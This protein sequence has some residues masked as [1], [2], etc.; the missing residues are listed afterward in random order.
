[1]INVRSITTFFSPNGDGERDVSKI[2]FSIKVADDATVDVVNLDGDR[3]RRLADGVR[4]GALPAAAAGRGTARATTA[5]VVPDG[6][7]RLRVALRDEG[8]S[9]I[10]QKTM[11]VDTKAPQLDR[12]HRRA[13][14]DAT[15]PRG[16]RTSSP[17]A[18]ARSTSTSVASRA[19]R[20]S[21]TSSAPTR[22]AS[23][24]GS[25]RS[26][27]RGR[28]KRA[29]AGTA[30]STASR[31]SPAPTSIQAE[32][33]DTAGN[34]GLSPAE[35]EPGAVQG[36]PRPDRARHHGAAAGAPGDRGRAHGVLRRRA[37]RGVPLAGAPGGR[38][39]HR[40]A[41]HG[42]GREPRV[43]R[44]GRPVGR[45]PARA[46][47]RPLVDDGAVPRPGP[48]ARAGAR[49]RADAHAGSAATRSTTRRST[50]SR[51]RSPRAT[52]CAG[53]ACTWARTA[54]RPASPRTSRRC[55]CSWT[56]GRSGT[57]SR[58]TSTSTSPATRARPTAKACSWP[59]R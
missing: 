25:R 29:D 54:C 15:I 3:V 57:T 51:T 48:R 8:R 41:R 30:S 43:P 5:R 23:R 34:V 12:L 1:M 35:L 47:L 42:D 38:G 36:P 59:A 24:S 32:V 50:A 17:R 37:R 9:A 40:Q 44:A 16:S 39:P 58:V 33:R 19:S 26:S 6:Q 7:Y 28:F 31:S 13:V 46:A 10:V 52:R 45:L 53:R 56:A 55:S 11:T 21:S 20:R 18:T 2:S 49:R 4:D 22:P 14:L 27:A